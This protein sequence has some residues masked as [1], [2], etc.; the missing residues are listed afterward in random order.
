MKMADAYIQQAEKHKYDLDNP[1]ILN[2]PIDLVYYI[3]PSSK[4]DMTLL[5]NKT[6]KI[7]IEGTKENVLQLV[8][9]IFQMRD[10]VT[11]VIEM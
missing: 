1:S 6:Q 7:E 9:Q 3:S 11:E 5:N 4:S 8:E 2:G 10:D